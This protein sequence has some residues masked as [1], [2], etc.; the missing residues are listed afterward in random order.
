MK[1]I[2]SLFLALALFT[3]ASCGS[4]KAFPSDIA[5]EDILKA[6]QSAGETPEAEVFYSE[7]EN[8]LNAVSLS[9]WAD[10]IYKESEELSLLSDYAIFCGAGTDTYEIAVLKSK[11]DKDT[12]K[13]LDLIERRKESLS[14]GD[15]GAYDPDFDY[16]IKNSVLKT[17]GRFVIFLITDNNEA[18]AEAIEKLKK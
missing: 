11:S 15:K 5:C 12:Q 13:L 10:G 7:S 3:L 6:A 1:R 14:L 2:I 9:L 17:D 8:N 16:K 4:N 18:A